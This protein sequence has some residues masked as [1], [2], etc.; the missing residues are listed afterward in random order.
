[1]LQPRP[2]SSEH[3]VTLKVMDDVDN[4][5]LYLDHKMLPCFMGN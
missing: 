4:F 5:F 1:M 2:E 3:D